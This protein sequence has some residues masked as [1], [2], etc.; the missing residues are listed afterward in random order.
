MKY[1]KQ[2]PNV[3]AVSGRTDKNKVAIIDMTI[4]IHNIDHLHR[5]VEKIKKVPDIYSVHRI[6]H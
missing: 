3:A 2:L 1:Y 5:I 6:I 4:T